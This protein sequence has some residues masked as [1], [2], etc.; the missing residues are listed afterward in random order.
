[1]NN[2]YGSK[3]EAELKLKELQDE[4]GH[5]SCP[6][7]RELCKKGNCHSYYDGSIQELKKYEKIWKKVEL[8]E[9]WPEWNKEETYIKPQIV[10]VRNSLGNKTQYEL[11]QDSSKGEDP[12]I[13]RVKLYGSKEICFFEVFPSCCNSPLV[14]GVIEV[15]YQ[16]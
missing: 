3:L 7:F 10:E 1:M 11:L 9:T 14:T 6:V 5:K 8:P 2:T 15:E 13:D 4:M 12:E 16:E